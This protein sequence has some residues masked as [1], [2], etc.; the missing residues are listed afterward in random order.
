M[1]RKVMCSQD[2]LRNLM[3]E[4]NTHFKT[5]SHVLGPTVNHSEL[6]IRTSRG[7]GYKRT[8]KSF[9]RPYSLI[10]GILFEADNCQP[11]NKCAIGY[12]RLL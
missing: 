10:C 5:R 9:E 6:L 2:M 3:K 8:V 7:L 1:R 11:L 4:L 12:R